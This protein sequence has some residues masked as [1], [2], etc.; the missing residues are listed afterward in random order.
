MARPQ[1]KLT[2]KNP[3]INFK[4]EGKKS[5][6]R[7]DPTPVTCVKCNKEF[8]LPFKPRNPEVYCDKC[9]KKRNRRP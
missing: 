8:V 7:K 9:F 2:K 4:K 5:T 3:H 1:N 6:A